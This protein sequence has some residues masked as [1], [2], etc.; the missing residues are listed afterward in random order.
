VI[1]MLGAILLG[2]VVGVIA[3][4]L[5]PLDAF[6]KMSGP[7]S[8]LVSIGIGLA[9]AL[10]GYWVFTGLFGIGDDDIFDWGGFFG[11]LIGSVVVLAGV[12]Y[13]AGRGRSSTPA[14]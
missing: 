13:F 4:V 12:T 3:R 7:V 1:D 5:V 11:A 9:G 6:R 14:P 8:W 10:L 2:F